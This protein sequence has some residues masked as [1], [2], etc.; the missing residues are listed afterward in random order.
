MASENEKDVKSV[1]EAQQII[2]KNAGDKVKSYTSM[3]NRFNI[4]KK[5]KC[6]CDRATCSRCLEIEQLMKDM[7]QLLRE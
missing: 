7:Q 5:K 3:F 6:D 1:I 2:F 4:I